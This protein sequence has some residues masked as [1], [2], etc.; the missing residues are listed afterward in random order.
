M[1]NFQPPPTWADPADVNPATGAFVFSNVWMKWFIDLI[2][3]LNNSG[4]VTLNHN[5]LGGL[6]GGG[7]VDDYYHVDSLFAQ[8]NAAQQAD[9]SLVSQTALQNATDMVF[10]ISANQEWIATFELDVGAAL[11]TTGIKLAV[12]TPAGA[13]LNVSAA[14][15]PDILAA[16]NA[17]E[18]RTT[19][20]GTALAFTAAL[21]AGVGNAS[22]RV[23]VWVLNGATP[24]SVQLQFAQNT[25]SLTALVLRKGSIMRAD[26]LL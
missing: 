11:G 19:T 25:S 2:T 6:Q 24:G 7:G 12:T 3:T 18:L 9:Q 20:S 17:A 15:N 22:I 4:G 5:D 13:T 21:E 10:S 1:S 8:T 16:A 26:R 14:L 23:S